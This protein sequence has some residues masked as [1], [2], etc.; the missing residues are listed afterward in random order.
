[1][2]AS[3]FFAKAFYRRYHLLPSDD[4]DPQIDRVV[5]ELTLMSHQDGWLP[6]ESLPRKAP[7]PHFE[8]D[9]VVAAAAALQSGKV[10]Q[11]T[12]KEVEQFQNEFAAYCGVKHAIV[13]RL[14][15]RKA[16]HRPGQRHP[17]PGAGP[18]NPG[19]RPRQH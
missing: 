6:P 19:D 9:E 15:R 13:R 11:W 14:L 5:R 7:W 8:K 16:R 10:N 2:L 12:G 3:R 17:G 18:Q 1:M 4:Y